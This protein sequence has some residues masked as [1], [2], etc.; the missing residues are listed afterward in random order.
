MHFITKPTTLIQDNAHK[1]RSVK[2]F[3][4]TSLKAHKTN[5]IKLEAIFTYRYKR[6]IKFASSSLVYD[7]VH[8]CAA[9]MIISFTAP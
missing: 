7:S 8:I 3:L 1:I 2:L 5:F 6:R 9:N 4:P